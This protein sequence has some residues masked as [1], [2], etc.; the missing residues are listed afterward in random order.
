MAQ[1]GTSRRFPAMAAAAMAGLLLAGCV[2]FSPLDN[3]KTAPPPTDSPF[4]RALFQDYSF[5]AHSF[6]DIGQASYT[7]F[8]QEGSISLAKNPNDTAALANAYASKAL[9]L[10]SGLPVDPEPSRELASHELRDRL[11]RALDKG[12]DDVPRDAARAQADYDCWLMNATVASQAQASAACRSSLNITLPRLETEV[13]MSQDTAEATP[14]A[15]PSPAAPPPPSSANSMESNPTPAAPPAPSAA[16]PAATPPAAET[17]SAP[18]YT[19]YFA[20]NSASLTP[21]DMGVLQKAIDDARAGGQP[22]ITVVGHTD[23]AG[24]EA[25]NKKLSIKRADAVRDALVALGARREAIETEGVG[26][27]DLA[28]PTG[29]GVRQPKNRRAVFTLL[30]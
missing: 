16:P 10:S 1:Y 13:H 6:G 30:I 22:K 14:P 8:D 21:E 9:Q 25:Y 24:G 27:S 15:A 29:N 11:V 12:R 18:G 5:L 28:V 23:T 26:E 7:T 19:V 3:L 2:N 17:A 4:D 20:F